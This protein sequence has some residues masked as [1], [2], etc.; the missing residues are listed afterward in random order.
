[1][2]KAIVP[3]VVVIITGITAIATAFFRKTGNN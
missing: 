2:K 3:T 1:M